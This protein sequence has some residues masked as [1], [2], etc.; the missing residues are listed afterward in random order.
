MKNN[1]LALSGVTL[2]LSMALSHTA[3]ADQ[4]I[5]D[6]LIVTMSECIG[7]DCVNGENFGFDTL[8]LK[9][10]NTRI[11]FD[12]TSSSGSFPNHD[13][14]LTANESD[15]GGLNKFSIE[16]ITAGKVP[17]TILGNAP[18]N[19]LYV[20]DNGYIGLGTSTP[21]V[22]LHMAQGDSPSIRL[23]QN[24]SSG[25]SAQT[26]DV[27]GN[28][29]NFFIRDVTHSSKLPFKILPSAPTDSFVIAA[30][31]NIGIGTKNPSEALHI[32]QSDDPKIYFDENGV[33]ANSWAAGI[34][35]TLGN[36]FAI[37][38]Q[39]VDPLTFMGIVL[40]PDG[41]IYMH[42][43][44]A[45]GSRWN[46]QLEKTTGKVLLSDDLDVGGNIVA[47]GTISPGSSRATKN[48]INLID[49]HKILQTLTNLDI[50]SW[51]YIRDA[52]KIMHIGPMAEEFFD[53]F[54]VGVDNK[55]ISPT[56]TSGISLAAIKA[57]M[58]K[59][60]DQNQKIES[61]QNELNELKSKK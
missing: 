52:G 6:D 11:K 24:T 32:R 3:S 12:D 53:T 42:N 38:N 21:V 15:N 44:T 26:W 27:V 5:A 23:E 39:G 54:N 41:D 57:L 8:R 40:Q 18:T 25:W 36:G 46:F 48:N 16:D 34:E 58:E 9:E 17:F 55:H 33:A 45:Q 4:V 14:Q 50:Y 61:M 49:G 35:A 43:G 19:S 29:T 1:Q 47:Q 2:A 30:S 31:G 28:E 51:S 7:N 59:L 60:E 10:N 56:D 37:T 13:W 20:K 22:R